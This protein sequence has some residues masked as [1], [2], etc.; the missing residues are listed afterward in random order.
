MRHYRFFCDVCGKEEEPKKR[1]L[2]RVEAYLLRLGAGGDQYTTEDEEDL[3]YAEMC[4]EC[5]EKV[6]KALAPFQKKK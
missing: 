5:F 3:L 2:V 6:K 1:G 4:D